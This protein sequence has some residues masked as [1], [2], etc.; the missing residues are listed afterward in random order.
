MD[1]I[2]L[3]AV[4][5]GET[6]DGGFMGQSDRPLSSKGMEQA[7][8][9][10]GRLESETIHAFY[11]SDLGRAV[12]TSERIAERIEATFI[13]DSRL[14]ERDIGIV[15]GLTESETRERHP[16]ILAFHDE[17]GEFY[18]FPQGESGQQH[19]ARVAD[20]LRDMGSRH[21][22]STVL[23]VTHGGTLRCM[24]RH[25]LEFSY[26]AV[27]RMDCDNASVNVFV[28]EQGEWRLHSW[29]DTSH[30]SPKV[31]T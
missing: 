27:L 26:H 12:Q 1:R 8:A 19:M 6:I 14:R 7:K 20:F 29:N 5:H 10:A 23:A 31:V 17:Q 30:L 22:A 4:R 2:K 9:L 16:E 25:V 24:L 18:V 3:I 21:E 11:T 13:P 28:Y 15:T